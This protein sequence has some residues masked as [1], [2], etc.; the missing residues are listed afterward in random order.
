MTNFP[1]LIREGF[2]ALEAD[3]YGR[4][5][6]VRDVRDT[7]VEGLVRSLLR[8][9]LEDLGH[10]AIAEATYP[11]PPKQRCDLTIQAGEELAYLEFK[12]CFDWDRAFELASN[13]D[14]D[15]VWK[16]V[17]KHL[18]KL[19][20]GAPPE[21]WRAAILLLLVMT[22]RP[23]EGDFNRW[24]NRLKKYYRDGIL[25]RAERH[26]RARCLMRDPD[27]CSERVFGDEV[28]NE[29]LRWRSV[30]HNFPQ[31]SP[32]FFGG[33]N[34]TGSWCFDATSLV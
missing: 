20:I 22:R 28:V 29:Y 30:S 27:H 13:K 24:R 26:S 6:I 1:N 34:A 15:D 7:K 8:N 25:A 3:D 18:S 23:S 31:L 16:D 19:K 21:S 2:K 17:G 14:N 9:H 11:N 10:I 4:R 5:L 33:Q 12:Q 32:H